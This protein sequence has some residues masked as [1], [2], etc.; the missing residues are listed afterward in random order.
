MHLRSSTEV[1][2][3]RVKDDSVCPYMAQVRQGD[4]TVKIA[5]TTIGNVILNIWISFALC[6]GGEQARNHLKSSL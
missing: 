5:L 2:R 3:F 1:V 4:K 6:R